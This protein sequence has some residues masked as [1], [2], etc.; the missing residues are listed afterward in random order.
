MSERMGW[1][2]FPLFGPRIERWIKN[3]YKIHMSLM[4]PLNYQ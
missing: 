2:V 4:G 3:K 1:D